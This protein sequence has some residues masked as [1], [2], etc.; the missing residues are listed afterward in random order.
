MFTKKIQRRNESAGLKHRRVLPSEA[1]SEKAPIFAF[2]GISMCMFITAFDQ[3]T[4]AVAASGI[5]TSFTAGRQLA[6][7]FVPYLIA[8]TVSAPILGRLSDNFGRRNILVCSVAAFAVGSLL[9]GLAANF[10]WLIA[11]RTIQGAGAGGM[12]SLAHSALGD[13]ISPRERGRYVMYF[14]VIWGIAMGLG[15]WLGGLLVE[16]NIWRWIF[17]LNIAV[18]ILAAVLLILRLPNRAARHKVPLH[19]ASAILL[20]VAVSGLS[21]LSVD[22]SLLPPWFFQGRSQL[23]IVTVALFIVFVLTEKLGKR[24]LFPVWL[25]QRYTF[26]YALIQSFFVYACYTSSLLVMPLFLQ[27]VVGIDPARSGALIAPLTLGTVLGMM[28]SGRMMVIS[29]RTRSPPVIGMCVA[30][31]GYLAIWCLPIEL[32]RASYLSLFVLA[33]ALLGI[34]FGCSI[35][36]IMVVVQNNVGKDDLGSATSTVSFARSIGGI[37]GVL[38]CNE[39]LV[40]SLPVR[41]ALETRELMTSAQTALSSMELGK[42]LR[43]IVAPPSGSCSY[44]FLFW[45]ALCLC[46]L[47]CGLRLKDTQL[48]SV[49]QTG[50]Q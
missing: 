40:W 12:L 20:V 9:C 35:P 31:M 3:A 27:V 28:I 50:N 39:I 2:V 4:L 37:V 49:V 26:N 7:I 23:A 10:A 25:F 19:P 45:A 48:R 46:A 34:G 36:P 13:V 42:D 11:F 30:F 38:A 15:P 8:S 6:W 16:N 14:S 33:T 43:G 17:W 32:D 44:L 41:T 24:S 22:R 18:S 47:Y 29:G 1:V 21:L 5:A